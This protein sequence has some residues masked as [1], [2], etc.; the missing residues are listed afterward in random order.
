MEENKIQVY[1]KIDKN[2]CIINIDSSIFLTNIAGWRQIDAGYGDKYSHAQGMYLSGPIRDD[3][4]RCNYK[5]VDSKV[6][7]LTVGEKEKLY[8]PEP[9]EPTTEET[10]LKEMASFKI[11][12][13]K[14]RGGH[15]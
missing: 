5:Y 14:L 2:N 7:E 3:F 4:G 9:Q 12:I 8:P 15:M 10:L 13:M 1:T 11:E 6:I